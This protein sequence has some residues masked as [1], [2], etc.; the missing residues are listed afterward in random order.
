MMDI[1]DFFGKISKFFS[2]PGNVGNALGEIFKGVVDE[3]TGVPQG[4]WYGALDTSVF[5]QYIWEFFITNFTC[6]MKMLQNIQSCFIYYFLDILGHILYL[7]FRI[8]FW[9]FEKLIPGTGSKIENMI[10]DNLDIADR[11]TISNLGFHIVH[12]SK[13]VRDLCYNC[14]R[15]RPMVFVNQTIGFVEDLGD[16]IIPLMIGGLEEMVHGLGGLVNAFKI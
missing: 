4:I 15:L 1:G 9:I 2:I 7:P 10:W 16:P 13:S 11:W 5:I 12:F 8:M 3:F 6:G 14:K